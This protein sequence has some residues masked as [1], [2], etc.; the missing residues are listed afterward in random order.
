MR[1]IVRPVVGFVV[2]VFSIGTEGT[3]LAQSSAPQPALQPPVTFT[4]DQDHQSMMDQL[5]IKAL[6]P[7]PS[8]DEKAP[9]HANYDESKANPFPNLPDPLTLNNGQKVTTPAMWW[10][11]RRPEIVEMIEKSVYGRVPGNVPRVTWTVTAVDHEMLGF[12][13]VT[14]KDL[15][16]HVDNS[17]CPQ[18]NVN[19]HMTLV[20]P[21]NAKGPVPVLMMFGRA[22]F[23]AP[24]EPVGAD[25]ERVNKAFEALLV[26][27]DSVEEAFVFG[28]PTGDGD[29]RVGCVLVSSV[30]EA[31]RDQLAADVRSWVRERA[32]T[33]KVPTALRVVTAAELPLTPTGKVSKRLLKDQTAAMLE[34]PVDAT[35]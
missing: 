3:G 13:P 18:I 7:G 4:A 14:V 9:N 8:G 29:Q 15:I 22:G 10:D 20:T 30:A 32:A 24:N 26:Q 33:Y 16:G 1:F 12:R 19:I 23:P 17:S 5:G 11:K 25:L 28:L 2:A 6:R 34:L 21:A 31:G 27:H 35:S